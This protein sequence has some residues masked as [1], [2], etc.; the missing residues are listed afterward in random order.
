MNK[1]LERIIVA[2]YENVRDV[3]RKNKISLRQAA[4]T[5]GMERVAQAT[6]VRGTG[7]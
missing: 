2:A 5:I 4:Y 7:F 3:S 6:M 1:K